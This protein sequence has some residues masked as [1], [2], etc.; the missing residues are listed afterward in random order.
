MACK[1]NERVRIYM[2]PSVPFKVMLAWTQCLMSTQPCFLLLSV[3]LTSS[4]G[5]RKA[6][7]V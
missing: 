5:A 2:K 4:G 1:V 6:V 7:K 3:L